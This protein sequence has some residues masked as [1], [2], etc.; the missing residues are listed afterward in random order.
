MNAFLF[1][2]IG[3]VAGW[4]AGRTVRDRGLHL[5]GDIIV[6]AFSALLGGQLFQSFAV[7]LHGRLLDALIISGVALCILLGMSL[8]ARGD[9]PYRAL[10]QPYA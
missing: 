2:L 4:L 7:V 3:V 9:T 6:G 8:I 10:H 1:I 5:A